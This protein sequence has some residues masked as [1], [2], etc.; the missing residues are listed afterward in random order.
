MSDDLHCE[1][2][3]DYECPICGTMFVVGMS[4][5]ATRTPDQVLCQKC[6][7]RAEKEGRV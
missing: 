7:E 4:S 5:K 1:E 2:W 6:Y 3:F